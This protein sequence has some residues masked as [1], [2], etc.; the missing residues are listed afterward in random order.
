MFLE[1]ILHDLE[2]YTLNPT[3]IF[4]KLTDSIIFPSYQNHKN[5]WNWF[6]VFT[7]EATLLSDQLSF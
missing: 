4:Q 3:N 5:V 7:M 1:N 2:D 6:T